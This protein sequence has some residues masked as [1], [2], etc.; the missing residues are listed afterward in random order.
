MKLKVNTRSRNKLLLEQK[1]TKKQ[2]REREKELLKYKKD[3]SEK[4]DKYNQ[5]NGE[6]T[7]KM[8][9][10]D[11]DLM[12]L[13]EEL[14]RTKT[15]LASSMNSGQP[16]HMNTRSKSNP[17]TVREPVSAKKKFDKRSD[18]EHSEKASDHNEPITKK[19]SQTSPKVSTPAKAIHTSTDPP[20]ALSDIK[21][22][23]SQLK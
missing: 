13:K 19:P 4:N 18:K 12:K 16:V 2:L 22:S 3:Y 20:K 15:R 5:L 11:F 9:E 8:K 6:F 7:R 21:N 14:E 10:K 1:K 17:S 23:I